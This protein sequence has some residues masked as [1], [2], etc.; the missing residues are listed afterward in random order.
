MLK[1]IRARVKQVEAWARCDRDSTLPPIEFVDERDFESREGVEARVAEITSRYP[2]D[3]E[4][5]KVIIVERPEPDDD[6]LESVWQK[7]R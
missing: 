4:G 7:Q 5:I 2:P 6:S 3:Y 1:S